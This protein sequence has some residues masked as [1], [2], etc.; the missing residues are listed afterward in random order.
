MSD[1]FVEIESLWKFSEG[2]E[3]QA[4]IRTSFGDVKAEI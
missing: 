2:Y 3:V 1:R 4:V